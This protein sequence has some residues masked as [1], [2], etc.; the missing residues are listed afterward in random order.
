VCATRLH[1]PI[2]IEDY[3]HED[4]PE[5]GAVVI[6]AGLCGTVGSLVGFVLALAFAC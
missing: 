1:V 3:P 5:R 4:I 6:L 2:A